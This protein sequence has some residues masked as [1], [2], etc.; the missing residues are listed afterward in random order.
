MLL[1]KFYGRLKTKQKKQYN[2]KANFKVLFLSLVLVLSLVFPS[3]SFAESTGTKYLAFTSD[4]HGYVDN[5]ETWL[6]NL[7][8][9]GVTS[10]DRMIF[11]GDY[12]NRSQENQS[13]NL[14]QQSKGKV[15]EIY[16]TG[17]D[18]VLV[19]GNHDTQTGSYAEGL[20]YSGE[21]YAVYAIKSSI[22]GGGTS[23]SGWSFLQ[24]DITNLE[25]I[26]ANTDS[27][28]PVFVVSHFPIHYYNASIQERKTGNAKQLLDVLNNHE[29]V[30]FMWGHNH[31]VGDPYYGNV[32]TKGFNIKT[33]KNDSGTDINF[34]YLAHGSMMKYGTNIGDSDPIED[35]GVLAELNKSNDDTTIK[36]TYKDLQGNNRNSKTVVF[37]SAS[38]PEEPPIEPPAE[39][40]YQE[41]GFFEDG[42][43]YLIV[44]E[45]SSG[46]KY[47]LT[48][49]VV[50]SERLKAS[51]VTVVGSQVTSTDVIET[52][53]WT[54]EKVGNNTYLKNAGG[55]LERVSGG[56]GLIGTASSRD[57]GRGGWLYNSTNNMLYT[58]STSE[59]APGDPFFINYNSGSN[60]YFNIGYEG[61]H[62]AVK[63]YKFTE[64]TGPTPVAVTGV[65]L[66]K[67]AFELM[68]GGEETL[69][70][71]VLPAN[72]NNKGVTWSSSNNSIAT[73]NA[74]GKVTAVAAGTATITVKT[75]DGGFEATTTVTV[76]AASV[77]VTGVTLNKTA[78]E[79]MIGG[80]ETLVESVLPANADNKG[81]TWSS[82]NN[83]IATVN[84][85]GKVTAVSAGTATIT[86]TTVDGNFA[87]QALVTIVEIDQVETGW[88]KENDTW[89]FYDESGNV[90]TGWL[91]T[92]GKWYFLNDQ[93]AM[94]TGWI[95]EGGK[96]YLLG[97]SGAMRVGWVQ[98]GGKWYYLSTSNGAMRV[99]WLKH[100][101]EWYYLS[102][103]NG[104]M[105]TGWVKSG[106]KWYYLEANG[107][108]A[109]SKW[110]NGKYYVGVD[111]AMYVSSW[112]PDGYYVDESGA[113]VRSA[114][115]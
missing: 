64:G 59:G 113:W 111:G 80:E 96:W 17:T 90:T 27:S 107:A 40:S 34:T 105:Q 114:R 22:T 1:D 94:Q 97:N 103:S 87:S 52:M 49:E 4:V 79:L 115:P 31:T 74:N 93:G 21:D 108:M 14:A 33:E 6:N 77:A 38:S 104:S 58:I 15:Q 76:K 11:G 7:K 19:R 71:S 89:Y 62:T 29:N 24:E 45:S 57:Q 18:V 102:T 39:G 95:R 92:G 85:N 5:L 20:V 75:A 69:V 23:T 60:S 100:D 9:S 78:F 81:V 53:K 46:N 44:G 8:D 55:Y 98:S 26:L 54:A 61:S 16:G 91:R 112:T 41:V 36:F 51:G 63:L 68:V 47:A 32:M 106:S 13:W 50:S 43:I 3:F 88:V 110:I 84:A 66:N 72:A 109:T 86:V 99:G 48:N 35:F 12:P 28:K 67:T 25:G 65:T 37:G 42:G 2:K 101:G 10:L 30:I 56:S 82:S 83:S 70:E 73:V